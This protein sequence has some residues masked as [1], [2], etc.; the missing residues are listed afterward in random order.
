MARRRFQAPKPFR[1]GHWWWIRPW[2]D[3]F[4]GGKLTR[5]Q[6]RL[7][8][9]P[10]GKGEREASRI[11]NEMLRPMNQGLQTIGSATRFRDYI[12]GTFRPLVLPQKASTTQMS[13]EGTLQKHL[14]PVFGDTLLRDMTPRTLQ[15][16][17][18]NL[19]ETD[20]GGTTVLK[21]KEVLSSSLK[22]AVTYEMLIKN[23]M[24]AVKVPRSK[25]VNK[26]KKKP[27]L[28]PEEFGRLLTLIV[29]PYATMIYVAVHSGLRVS[30]LIGLRWGDIHPEAITIDERYCRGDWSITKTE[31]SSTTIGVDLS[32]I[33]RIQR[34]RSLEVELRWGGKEAKRRI[35]VVR[36]G[37]PHDLVFQSLRNGGTMN[38][39]N[40]VRR[41]L[42]PAA[43]TLKI[44]PKKATWQSLR[45]SR[46]TWMVQ[47][48]IDPKTVQA[49]MRHS[50][51]STTMEFYAQ[52]VTD[53]A[54]RAS[55]RT[56]EMVNQQI[57][58]ARKA[59]STA[60]N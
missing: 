51:I 16:F 55:A 17:M 23:P 21:I 10:A 41:H 31:G 27:Y 24:A 39:Q 18:N 58:Q 34:L 47:A 11:A 48:D 33:E 30:E 53:S 60:V 52:T 59:A 25:V 44:D 13:Y 4:T 35:K 37:G 19:A 6:K 15:E 57:D 29:E 49:S 43:E 56:M 14:V 50:R 32:V 9:C 12:D 26:R 54:R 5:K 8:V 36:S 42:R 28:T 45:R 3:E 2:Q 22:W 20:L 40:I 7:K 1:E 46:A 38:D